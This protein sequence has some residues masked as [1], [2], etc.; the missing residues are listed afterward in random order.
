MLVFVPHLGVVV[1]ISAIIVEKLLKTLR[2]LVWV[3]QAP[4]PHYVPD[5]WA[6]IK[7]PS[8]W[9]AIEVMLGH[10]GQHGL[11]GG[12][13]WRK[14]KLSTLG[15]ERSLRGCH[16]IIRRHGSVADHGGVLPAIHALGTGVDW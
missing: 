7:L 13:W 2:H 8:R 3:P 4:C 1:T 15:G 5:C 6:R 9:Q 11:L 16:I 12:G 10:W 14:L